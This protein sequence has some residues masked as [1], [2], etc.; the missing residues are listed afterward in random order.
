MIDAGLVTL[1][2]LAGG[3]ARRLGGRDKALLVRE[4]RTQLMHALAA[5]A[6]PFRERLL[7]Y[8]RDPSGL[9][10]A[11]LRVV[12]DLTPGFAGPVAALEAL[13]A[14]CRSPWLM[15]VPVD[16]LALPPTLGADLLA[17]AGED[18]TTVDDADGP[19]PL[20]AL[21][22]VEA[23]RKACA[24]AL[25]SGDARAMQ[26]RQALRLRVLDL[27]PARLGNLNR[28]E[29]LEASCATTRSRSVATSRRPARSSIASPPRTGSRS[30]ASRSPA[31]SAP[32]SPRTS[33]PRSR[34]RASTIPRWTASP[35]AA[36]TARR[37]AASSGNSS[38]APAAACASAKASACA[39]PPARS[40]PKARTRS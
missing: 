37:R 34:C 31:R 9:A 5:F 1:G 15:T 7:S 23:L 8:N 25:R 17:N 30:S 13:A 28:L 11:N 29:D 36:A 21:W 14:E 35:C 19:Q 27:A 3:Q 12:G 40:C 20:V 10:A 2:I 39:L 33:S 38:P 32:C 26:V 6:L 22:R 4:G 16:C 18:G 24:A